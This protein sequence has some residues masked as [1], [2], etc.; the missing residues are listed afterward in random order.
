MAPLLR[1]K[2]VFDDHIRCMAAK[3]R[4]SRGRKNARQF[5]LNLICDLL[6]MPKRAPL[7]STSTG[8]L[9]QRSSSV[10]NPFRVAR[11]CAPGSVRMMT[12][13]YHPPAPQLPQRPP[14]LQIDRRL[15][16]LGCPVSSPMIR[17]RGPLLKL[18]ED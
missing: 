11:G 18:L 4:L 15:P 8:C 7:T 9:S 12:P 13:N 16:V 17:I 10:S 2:F 3:Q 6:G 14:I 5:K 1:A